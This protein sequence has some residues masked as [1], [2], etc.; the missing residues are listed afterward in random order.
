MGEHGK[1]Y[2]TVPGVVFSDLVF[3]EPDLVLG[4]AEAFFDGPARTSDLD[5]F[6]ESGPVRVMAVIVGEFTVVD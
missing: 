2:V 6:T 4:R 5:E 3:I 1:G